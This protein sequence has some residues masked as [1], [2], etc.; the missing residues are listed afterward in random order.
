MVEEAVNSTVVWIGVL[1]TLSVFANLIKDNILTRLVQHAAL[2]VAVGIGIVM[3][4]KQFLQP[5]WWTPIWEGATGESTPLGMLWILALVPGSLWYFQLSKKNFWV[6]TIITGLF[7]GTA[8]GLAFKDQMLRILPQI[9]DSI[10][11][12]N[13]FE[14]GFTWSKFFSSLNGLLIL[15]GMLTTLLYFFFSIKA[16][17][18]PVV[19][20]SMRL[21][22]IMIMVTL[23]GMF[24]ATVMTRMAYLLNRMI[25]LKNEWITEQIIH[26]LT[27][28]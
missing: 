20:R 4:W 16:E 1:V 11:P 18:R 19:T 10:Q 7:I 5:K 9:S 15:V 27:G 25:F 26:R 8:A 21:G 24:G 28:G 2:G 17:N 13:P 3:A 12:L 22:R 23:G 14:G 6:S